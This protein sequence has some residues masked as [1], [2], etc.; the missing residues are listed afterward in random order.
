MSLTG[1][2]ILLYAADPVDY[3]I[4]LG[5]AGVAGIPAQR[6]TGNFVQAWTAVAS[7]STCVIA[8]GAPALN[9][10]FFNPCGWA[11][12]DQRAGGHT[13]FVMVSTPQSTLPGEERVSECRRSHRRHCCTVV[14]NEPS[15]A[16]QVIL[17]SNEREPGI[18]T[19]VQAPAW[20]PAAP[21]CAGRVLAWQYGENGNACQAGIDTDL[22]DPSLLQYLW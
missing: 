16:T 1:N 12:P 21:P 22:I 13:P 5:A 3:R 10:L 18:S 6:V 20:D 9:A 8:V 7:G 4:A 2:Q 11:N 14:K 15:I 19:K 17:W